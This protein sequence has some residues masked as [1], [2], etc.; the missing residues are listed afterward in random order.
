MT[1]LSVPLLL[2]LV[3]ISA[4][5]P[6]AMNGVLPATSAVMVEL[7]TR[8]EVVQMVL[9]VFL[10]A[11]LVSQLV[12]GPAADRYGRRPVML[13]S[14]CVFTLGSIGCAAAQ[15]IESLLVAR[16]IQGV[17]GAVCMF[18]PRT[19]VRDIYSQNKAAS[20]IGYITTAMMVAPLFAPAF[21]GWITDEYSWRYMYVA[22]AMFGLV[23][24]M[25]C[26]RYQY[27]T[28]AS[29]NG[30]D[31]QPDLQPEQLSVKWPDKG[32]DKGPDKEL[33]KELDKG[34]DKGPDKELGKRR[35]K[36]PAFFSS[37]LILLKDPAFKACALM[38]AGT[39]GVYYSF[40]AGAPYVALES[41]GMSASS[42]GVWF[43][44]VAIGYLSGNFI[45]GRFS[46]SSDA[47]WPDVSCGLKQWRVFTQ[48][49]FHCNERKTRTCSL[50]IGSIG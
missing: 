38:L 43:S 18:L 26:Y 47:I 17:G 12:L 15:N 1:R 45:A 44:L 49:V 14:L 9:T 13:L 42:Y 32:P 29:L 2:L 31:L 11:N 33:D 6:M 19:V 28:L 8:F 24:L 22:L 16:F 34:P 4:V 48:H 27:E 40:L 41:R 39:V 46:A 23:L 3:G 21:G 20:V 5:G 50:C 35:D 25:M 37:S 10:I 30:S 36:K 7:S